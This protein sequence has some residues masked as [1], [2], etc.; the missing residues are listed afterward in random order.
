MHCASFM[1]EAGEPAVRAF[2]L[3][4]VL[5]PVLKKPLPGLARESSLTEAL[6]SVW[7]LKF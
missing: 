5:Q 4:D 1:T 6:F 7:L 2:Q 3:R